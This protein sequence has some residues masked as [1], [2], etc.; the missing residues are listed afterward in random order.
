MG[1][2][3]AEDNVPGDKGERGEWSC[4]GTPPKLS[5]STLSLISE[6]RKGGDL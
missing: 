6:E 3:G 2:T 5:N 1:D 4:R